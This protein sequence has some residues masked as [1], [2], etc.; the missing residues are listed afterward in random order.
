[1]FALSAFQIPVLLVRGPHTQHHTW[2][3]FEGGLEFRKS[4]VQARERERE[5]DA[6]KG[7]ISSRGGVVRKTGKADEEKCKELSTQD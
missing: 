2:F 6:E 5:V 7:E 4:V 3:G 1:M